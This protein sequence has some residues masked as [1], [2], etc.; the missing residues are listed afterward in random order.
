MTERG[1][2]QIRRDARSLVVGSSVARCTPDSLE[3]SIDERC[4]PVARRVR[5]T[6]RLRFSGLAA[7]AFSLGRGHYWMPLAPCAVAEVDLA[8]ST[9]RGTAYL[10]SNWGSEALEQGF[11]EWHWSRGHVDDETI[12]LYDMVTRSGVHQALALRFD[13]RGAPHPLEAPAPCSLPKTGW[14]I[15]RRTRADPGSTTRVLRTL[16]DGPFYSRSLIESSVHGR[17]FHAIHESLSLERFGSRWVQALLP[18]RM[19][20]SARGGCAPPAAQAS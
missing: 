14:R 20:R 12:V 19:P 7:H 2:A 3:L 11:R 8:G 18:F 6:V 5:G 9:W 15:A 10:D 4:A 17:R 16:E 13:A 1:A